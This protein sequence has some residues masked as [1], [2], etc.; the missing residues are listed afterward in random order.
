[1]TKAQSQYRKKLASVYQRRKIKNPNR[2]IDRLFKSV[3]PTQDNDYI[4]LRYPKGHDAPVDVPLYPFVCRLLKLGYHVAG[5][6]YG[7]YRDN[8]GFIMVS[9]NLKNKTQNTQKRLAKSLYDLFSGDCVVH[10]KKPKKYSDVHTELEYLNNDAIAINFS[11]KALKDNMQD[12]KLKP[13]KAQALP[14]ASSAH[15]SEK[16]RQKVWDELMVNGEIDTE[17]MF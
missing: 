8:G 6:D 11:E 2:H 1:M 4:M 7:S 13:S 17:D 3:Y 9:T 16:I 12:L 10:K 5:W 15:V 14:G